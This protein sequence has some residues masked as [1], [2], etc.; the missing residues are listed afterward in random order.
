MSINFSARSFPQTRLRRMR[1]SDFSRRLIAETQLT[2]DDLIYPIFIVEGEEQR[3]AI[4]SMPGISRLSI[5]NLLREA[6]ELCELGVPAI[7]LFPV[8][9][10]TKKSLLAEEAY[11]A[12]GLVQRAVR[13]LKEHC[14][15]LGVIT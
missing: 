5:D 10:S 2:V 8:I 12:T 9:D 14:P 1:A 11:S 7:A 6:K 3:I 4:D 15:E 13:A